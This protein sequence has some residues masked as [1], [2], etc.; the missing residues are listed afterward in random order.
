M[1][2]K[3]EDSFTD[4]VQSER[5]YYESDQD[6]QP[7]KVG[8]N[9]QN[10]FLISQKIGEG[11]FGSVFKVLDR[12]NN[13]AQW[14]MKVEEDEDEN[15]LLEREIKVL[16]ELRKQQGFPQIKFYGQERGYTYCIMTMLGKNLE[17]IFRKLGGVMTLA[18]VLRLAIQL[19]R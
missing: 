15:S 19:N 8:D 7:L 14:A 4:N 16:I 9:I 12:K 17:Q 6:I 18:T 2:S 11:S 13:N 5:K 3:N 10:R 1:I